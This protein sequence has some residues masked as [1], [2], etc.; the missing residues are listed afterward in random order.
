MRTPER[1][2]AWMASALFVVLFVVTMA[3]TMPV[4]MALR[5]YPMPGWTP[6]PGAFWP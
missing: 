1:V 5:M 6:A 3:E 4:V 2:I